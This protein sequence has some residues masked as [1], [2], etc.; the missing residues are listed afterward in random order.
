VADVLYRRSA[1]DVG[2]GPGAP[3]PE[4]DGGRS[5]RSFVPRLL[6]SL[7]SRPFLTALP[8]VAFAALG[9]LSVKSSKADYVSSGVLS[10][11]KSTLLADLAG[12]GADAP[13][14]W[15]TQAAL[16]SKDINEL[17][18][19]NEFAMDVA[20][21]A[22]LGSALE[23]GLM[24]LSDVRQSISAYPSGTNLVTI[25]VATDDPALSLAL[26]TSTI[27][28][29]TQWVIDGDVA[30][31]T[32]AEAFFADLLTTYESDLDEA[33]AALSAYQDAHP[34]EEG[35]EPKQTVELSQLES[36]V[37][38]ATQR[39]SS[40]IE[41][42]E[43]ARLSTATATSDITQRLRV[44]DDPTLPFAPESSRKT[45][46]LTIA[47][48]VIVG[49]LFAIGF[50]AAGAV[51]DRSVRYVGDVQSRLHLDVLAVV[52]AVRR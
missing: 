2:Y 29:F 37:D 33:R 22:G 7:F 8:I 23:S 47:T 18:G 16:T 30:Q 44:V 19:T 52:P 12:T 6:E 34:T 41:K 13:F 36:D 15:E 27:K 1:D 4:G 31:S 3:S 49:M 39:I 48:F 32:A 28:S 43:D 40:A 9:V 25:R 35:S 46:V 45:M 20:K 24:L 11:S 5:F 17:L 51:L 42:N 26:A 38:L 21:D 10:V 14:S 50:V